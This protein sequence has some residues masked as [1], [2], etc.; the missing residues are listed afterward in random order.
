MLLK[1]LTVKH[2]ALLP[3]H[4]DSSNVSLVVKV[5]SVMYGLNLLQT[6]KV[7]DS[8]S[9]TQSSVVWFLVNLSQ[10]LKKVW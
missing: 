2:S 1:Y 10:R 5:N 3:K 7:K 4:V 9:K 6:K 8:N